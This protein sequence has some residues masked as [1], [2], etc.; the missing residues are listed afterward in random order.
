[1]FTKFY[2]EAVDSGL[3]AALGPE[4]TQTLLCLARYMGPDGCCFPGLNLLG[5][6]LGIGRQ[7]AGERINSLL[8]FRFHGQPVVS[9]LGRRRRSDGTLGSNAYRAE[10]VSGLSIFDGPTEPSSENDT[11]S[12]ATDMAATSGTPDMVT[13]SGRTDMDTMSRPTSMAR[14]SMPAPDTNKNHSYNE[15]TRVSEKR[16]GGKGAQGLVE[17]FHERLGHKGQRPNPR[18]LGQAGDLIAKYGLERAGF[19]RDFAIES[20]ARTKYD[21]QTFGA[22]LRYSDQA[23][24]EFERRAE[25]SAHQEASERRQA[26]KDEERSYEAWRHREL[27][28]MRSTLDPAELSELEESA[29]IEVLKRA[30]DSRF[31]LGTLVSIEVDKALAARF[32]LP[33][34]RRGA[35]GGTENPGLANRSSGE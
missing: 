24:Y 14:S 33:A 9:F 27:R 10:P 8:A 30:R 34:S 25:R 32:E 12:G 20:A 11:T 23:L 4:R 17:G 19:I 29:R 26:L 3:L 15:N 6:R 18:E 16:R 31:G 7:S 2:F 1:M 28:R 21:M 22:V 13:M 35:H 5:D